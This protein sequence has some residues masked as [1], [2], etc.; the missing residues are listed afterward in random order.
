M[1]GGRQ[2]QS[3]FVFLR[4]LDVGACYIACVWMGRVGRGP[5]VCVGV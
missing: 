2:T 4:L 5:R 1:V 3:F